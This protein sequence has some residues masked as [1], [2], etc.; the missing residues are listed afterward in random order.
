MR[1][2]IFIRNL[3][4]HARARAKERITPVSAGVIHLIDASA[5][6]NRPAH[7]PGS[8]EALIG[9]LLLLLLL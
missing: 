8:R 5:A 7:S 6:D 1:L 4:P 3:P 9:L 2:I